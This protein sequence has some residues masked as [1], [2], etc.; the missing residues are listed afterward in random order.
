MS[1]PVVTHLAVAAEQIVDQLHHLPGPVVGQ[2]I[3]D[4]LAVTP[5]AHEPLDQVWLRNQALAISSIEPADGEPAVRL[6]D[7]RTGVPARGVVSVIVVTEQAVDD[8]YTHQDL[9]AAIRRRINL[10]LELDESA[11]QHVVARGYDPVY[12]AR[13]LK[14]AFQRLIENPLANLLLEKGVAGGSVVHGTW[15]D[16]ELVLT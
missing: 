15:Q 10:T 13:P 12:G 4:R 14:R 3:V 11:M 9:R 5:G 16:D 1:L 2:G 6:V 7:Q 8:V